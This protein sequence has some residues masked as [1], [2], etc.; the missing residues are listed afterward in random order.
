MTDTTSNQ[1]N[2]SAVQDSRGGSNA[3][4]VDVAW[5]LFPFGEATV[6]VVDRFQDLWGSYLRCIPSECNVLFVSDTMQARKALQQNPNVGVV[7]VQGL[8]RRISHPEVDAIL[9]NPNLAHARELA[10]WMVA[11]GRSG[12]LGQWLDSHHNT[13]DFLVDLQQQGFEGLVQVVS[14]MTNLGQQRQLCELEGLRVQYMDKQDFFQGTFAPKADELWRWIGRYEE[15]ER[16]AAKPL[17]PHSSIGR[18]FDEALEEVVFPHPAED[19]LFQRWEEALADL[20]QARAAEAAEMALTWLDELKLVIRGGDVWRIY[21]HA[22]MLP[23]QSDLCDCREVSGTSEYGWMRHIHPLH[24]DINRATWEIL[25]AAGLTAWM[26][27]MLELDMACWR[28]DSPEY[29]KHIEREYGNKLRAFFRPE[30][31]STEWTW[32]RQRRRC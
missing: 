16:K 18:R 32:A 30:G 11:D 17:N 19:R 4:T 28:P 31:P 9:G 5:K 25:D 3:K 21:I 29:G 27:L 12:P 2:S 13:L 1:P 22:S 23:E 8:S 7:F 14:R 24:S 10:A 6:L 15:Y 26:R 20:W